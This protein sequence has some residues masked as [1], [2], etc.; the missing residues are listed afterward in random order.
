MHFPGMGTLD[1]HAHT[2][3]EGVGDE[4]R[5]KNQIN[6]N[7]DANTNTNT[8][9]NPRSS[10][11]CPTCH[12]HHPHLSAI[13]T[14]SS[15]SRYSSDVPAPSPRPASHPPLTVTAELTKRQA[16]ASDQRISLDQDFVCFFSIVQPPP[17]RL[18][19]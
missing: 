10:L 4:M 16:P 7:A 5:K 19:L 15:T 2:T 8:K 6:R 18:L 12:T 9:K 13:H 3:G 14:S 17:P 11:R 1:S